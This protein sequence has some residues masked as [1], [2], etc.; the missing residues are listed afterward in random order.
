MQTHHVGGFSAGL[1]GMASSGR[2][3]IRTDGSRRAD[4]IALNGIALGV[5]P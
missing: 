5:P 2:D 4:W 3:W 1:G